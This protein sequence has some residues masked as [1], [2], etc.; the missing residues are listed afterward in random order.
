MKNYEKTSYRFGTGISDIELYG[1]WQGFIVIDSKCRVKESDKKMIKNYL[2]TA[3]TPVFEKTN[4][5]FDLVISCYL[6][7]KFIDFL[8]LSKEVK[9]K[10]LN[11]I[12]YKTVHT[13]NLLSM[14]KSLKTKKPTPRLIQQPMKTNA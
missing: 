13:A 9:E 8:M 3:T 14:R 7:G 1:D 11:E 4:P 6:D 5:K 2:L 10:I 12:L